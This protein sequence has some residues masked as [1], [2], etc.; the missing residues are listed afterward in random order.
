MKSTTYWRCT[1]FVHNRQPSNST[2]IVTH[3]CPVNIVGNQ[4][5]WLSLQLVQNSN[6]LDMKMKQAICYSGDPARIIRNDRQGGWECNR[7]VW[8]ISCPVKSI[9]YRIPDNR[10]AVPA[11]RPAQA[12][13]VWGKRVNG[14]AVRLNKNR[15]SLYFTGLYCGPYLW[16]YIL[17]RK[18][19]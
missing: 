1:F 6:V 8:N 18:T 14:M 5:Q 3:C 11:R 9:T 15:T 2:G 12:S 19:C 10:Y 7:I 17:W 16:A 13:R 4:Y